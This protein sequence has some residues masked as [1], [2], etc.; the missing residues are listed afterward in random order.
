MSK[1]ENEK[2]NQYQIKPKTKDKFKPNKAKEIIKEILSERLAEQKYSEI[3]GTNK[4]I[5]EH[6]KYKLKEVLALQRY[7]Y[8]VQVTI[9]EQLG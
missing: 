7:K 2:N 6:I 3:Q 1:K 4:D 8:L 9:G 5:A